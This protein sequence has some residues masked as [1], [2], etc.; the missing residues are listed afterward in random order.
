[1]GVLDEDALEAAMAEN[2]DE[3]LALLVDM[4]GATDEKLRA[5]ARR[6]AG[7]VVLDRV[8]MG[9][10]RGRGIGR[11]QT[12][13]ADRGGDLDIDASLSA[14]AEARALRRPPNLE[15]LSSRTWARPTLALCL[16]ID[17]SG[18][19]AG[20]RL[21]AAALTAAACAWRAPGDYAVLSFARDV[22]VLRDM[23]GS[24]SADTVVD[25][26]LGLR[27]H[28]VTAVAGALRAAGE[29]LAFTQAARRV[30]VLLSDCRA[31]DEVDPVPVAARLPELLILAPA[32]DCDAAADLA[33]RS[34]ARWAGVQ[35]AFDAPAALLDLLSR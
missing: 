35:G 30:T 9:N 15:D 31:T 6:L 21:A 18:S 34:G 8:R 25:R 17:A 23:H 5:A 33:A 4:G 10:P 24:V 13:P 26:I 29:Q 19:M 7:R 27:G 32:E 20:T 2:P 28:G 12:V 3:T 22:R 14:I 16:V 1:V 11:L